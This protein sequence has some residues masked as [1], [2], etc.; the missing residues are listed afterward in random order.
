M[1]DLIQRRR[2]MMGS[3]GNPLPY[4]A[5]IEYLESGGTQYIDLGMFVQ[6]TDEMYIDVEAT[7]AANGGVYGAYQSNPF[8]YATITQKGIW[9][10]TRYF[11]GSFT[12]GKNRYEMAND[13]T[14]FYYKPQGAAT[15]TSL[16]ILNR[17]TMNLNFYLFA[18]NNNGSPN[19]GASK[20]YSFSITRDGVLLMDLIPVRV[21]TTGYMYDR[22]SGQLFGNDGTGDFVLGNDKN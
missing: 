15:Y 5:E 10:S 4:D 7:S 16:A 18:F 2:E 3:G 6:Y 20:I 13:D 1:I 14:N 12:I 8:C 21:G 17:Y 11:T 9:L 22:V 19:C